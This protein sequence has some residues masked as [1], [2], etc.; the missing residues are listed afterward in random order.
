MSQ[1]HAPVP[2][3]QEDM[4]A[5]L[6]ERAIQQLAYVQR[7]A[8]APG[9]S[10]GGARRARADRDVPSSRSPAAANTS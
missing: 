9:A 4:H 1:T 6:K 7:P 10:T 3:W 8:T 2:S 5:V